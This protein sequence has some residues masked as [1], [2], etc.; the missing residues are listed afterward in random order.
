MQENGSKLMKIVRIL[1]IFFAVLLNYACSHP[2]EIVGEGDV[3]SSGGRTCT[4]EDFQD[5][6]NNCTKNFV[7]EAYQETYYAEPR[8][9]WKFHRWGNYCQNA[10]VN[11]CSFDVPEEAV[12]L[13]LGMTLPPLQAVFIP[14]SGD[15]IAVDGNMWLKPD[16]FNLITWLEINAVCPASNNGIC[17]NGG[18][19]NGQDMSGRTWA[20][21]DDTNALF[22]HYIGSP[23]L[24]PGQDYYE[25]LNSSWA[26]SFIAAFGSTH[27]DGYS[28]GTSGW[29]RT[30][31]TVTSVR[32]ADY[33]GISDCF[34][35]E[36][37]SG[38]QNFD[39]AGTIAEFREDIP[40]SGA[41][42]YR[43]EP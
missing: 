43:P 16:L 37:C 19:L 34:L 6:L 30:V 38:Q 11:T 23:V 36:N 42:F 20:S 1:A 27:A 10:T 33:V 5:G 41:W 15:T 28:A 18:V 21:V 24:G 7:T 26:P 8:P 25:E 22:N 17:V 2:I 31:S 13:F 39:R 29:T 40:I 32:F 35:V 14:D 3:W 9:G 12:H 4:L